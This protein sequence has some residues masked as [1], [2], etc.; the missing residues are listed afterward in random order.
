MGEAGGGWNGRKAGGRDRHE[1]EHGE[2]DWR[3]HGR[4]ELEVNRRRQEEA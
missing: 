1:T 3:R 4:E 2:V